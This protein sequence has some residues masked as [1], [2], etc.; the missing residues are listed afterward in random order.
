MAGA[1]RKIGYSFKRFDES[2]KE[3]SAVRALARGGFPRFHIYAKTEGSALHLNLHLDQKRPSYPHTKRAD[4][5]LGT[6]SRGVNG[7]AAARYGVGV[8]A[9]SGEHES[10]AVKKEASRIRTL[11]NGSFRSG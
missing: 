11:L 7:E 8:R 9:H 10:P 3:T 2:A 5:P 4:T 6:S 1:L